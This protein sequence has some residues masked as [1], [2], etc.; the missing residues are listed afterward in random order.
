MKCTREVSPRARAV[1]L[2]TFAD[3]LTLLFGFFI[4]ALATDTTEATVTTRN[5]TEISE[6]PSQVSA[7]GPG[8]VLAPT[9]EDTASHTVCVGADWREIPQENQVNLAVKW[10]ERVVRA[11]RQESDATTE[12]RTFVVRT[13]D[14]SCNGLPHAVKVR[15]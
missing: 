6:S 10:S 4:A 1:W 3:L 15:E 13:G 5:N 2:V 8:I 11:V 9:K 12:H 7:A 14:D